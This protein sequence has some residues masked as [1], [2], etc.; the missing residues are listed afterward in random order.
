MRIAVAS[1]PADH[2]KDQRVEDV[3]DPQPLVVDG[4]D[5]VVEP[6]DEPGAL[7]ARLAAATQVIDSVDIA[8]GSSDQR[9]VSR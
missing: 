6:L 9:R 1:M 4:G 7:E 3:Q 8:A 2:Q 5:P